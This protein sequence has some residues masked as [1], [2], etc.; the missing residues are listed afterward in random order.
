MVAGMSA[1]ARYVVV[2]DTWEGYEALVGRGGAAGVGAVPPPRTGL[3]KVAGFGSVKL[4]T[5]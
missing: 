3:G 4:K 2:G 5:L 1:S